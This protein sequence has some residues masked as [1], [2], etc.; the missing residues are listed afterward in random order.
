MHNLHNLLLGTAKHVMDV[1]KRLEV[2]NTKDYEIIQKKVDNFVCP[3]EIGRVPSK[4]LSGFS[5]F[6][7]EQWKNWTLFQVFH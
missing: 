7:A 2:I 4:I 1:W 5:G 3:P 6:T